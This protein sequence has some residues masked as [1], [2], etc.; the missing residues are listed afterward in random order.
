MVLLSV[1]KF[2]ASVVRRQVGWNL[3]GKWGRVSVVGGQN[4]PMN[5]LFRVALHP[6]SVNY[7]S[8]QA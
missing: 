1:D 3:G 7:R 5:E 8:I 4:I 2:Q 6:K